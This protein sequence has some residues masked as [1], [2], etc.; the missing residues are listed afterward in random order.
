[1]LTILFYLRYTRKTSI[2][3]YSVVIF[4][5]FL[6]LISKP[7]IVTLPFALLLLDYWPLRRTSSILS[8]PSVHLLLEKIPML[9][10]SGIASFF[11]IMAK[12]QGT[13]IDSLQ[14]YPLFERILHAFISYGR[15]ILKFV[16]PSNLSVYYPYEK[17]SS[18]FYV[19]LSIIF[20]TTITILAI[21]L[22]K[23][24]PYLFVG[25]FWYIGTLIPVI[26][27]VKFSAFDMA[28]R[29][30]Y[31]PI[32]GLLIIIAWGL[33]QFLA[34]F[35]RIDSLF[36]IGSPV[37]II[38]LSYI[39]WFQ[40]GN[41]ENSITL[42][43]HCLKHTN[44]NYLIHNNIGN[45]FVE[46]GEFDK[47]IHHYNEAVK[48]RDGY[49]PAYHNLGN[50]YYALKKYAPAIENFKLAAQTDPNNFIA[51]HNLG[52]IYLELGEISKSKAMYIKTLEI[53]RS[54]IPA[55]RNLR[56]LLSKESEV[57]RAINDMQLAIQNNF[58]EC[59][60][61]NLLT[62]KKIALQN[63]VRTFIK[64]FN[65]S[66]DE[67][68]IGFY[69]TEQFAQLR[70]DYASLLPDFFKLIDRCEK[71]FEIFYHVACIHAIRGECDAASRWFERA[72]EG[73]SS[74]KDWTPK[75]GCHNNCLWF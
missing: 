40:I 20:M 45:S 22:T 37:T 48:I 8:K 49:T 32:I 63:L 47:A 42:F 41:W 9:I 46:R 51:Y 24:A 65:I 19:T 62:E 73:D 44:K 31:I 27:I 25:W 50:T 53:N 7:M 36:S 71:P 57:E 75:D 11:A 28:D 74:L 30:M 17:P 64:R 10:L 72:I 39:S 61:I 1:M 69:R 59:N 35:N 16:W 12:T 56:L 43:E 26:G 23:K 52:G 60:S 67:C 3:N 29:F 54:Y 5:F 58:N 70:S 14:D 2:F 55:R 6:G 13:R 38:L 4:I 21:R 34:R 15:Y 18:F 68:K 66:A 33:P